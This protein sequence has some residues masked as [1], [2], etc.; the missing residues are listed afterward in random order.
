VLAIIA[1]GWTL[2]DGSDPRDDFQKHK[3]A[4]RKT[5]AIST[6][7]GPHQGVASDGSFVLRSGRLAPLVGGG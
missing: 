7:T 4:R 3:P 6:H 1:L 5:L 2:P